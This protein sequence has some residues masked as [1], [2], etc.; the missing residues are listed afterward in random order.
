MKKTTLISTLTASA[1]LAAGFAFA[2]SAN[3]P[4]RAL[5]IAPIDSEGTVPEIYHQD[6]KNGF[7]AAT[8]SSRR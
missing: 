6:E 1:L 8:G 3:S 5:R 7:R 2:Q 4:V